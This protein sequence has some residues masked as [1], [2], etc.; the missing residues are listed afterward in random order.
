MYFE[1]KNVVLSQINSKDPTCRISTAPAAVRLAI[2][3]E[4][5]GLINPPILLPKKTQ[6][7]IIS[8]FRRI[9]ACRE[10]GWPVI[11]A[12][13]VD[14]D[15]PPLDCAK[16]AI[17]ENASQRSLNLIELTRAFHMLSVLIDDKRMMLQTASALGL[18]ENPSLVEKIQELYHLPQPIQDGILSDTISLT[19]ALELDKMDGQ[20]G[21]QFLTLFEHLKLGLNRQREFITLVKEIAKREKITIEQV[22]QDEYL[23]E[24]LINPDMDRVQKTGKIRSY[25]R[26][27]RFPEITTAERVFEKDVKALELGRGLR[28]IP[29]T[30]FESSDYALMIRFRSIDELS[31]RF[32]RLESLT[33]NPHFHKILLK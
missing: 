2:S 4:K 31:T 29:P 14:P 25:L 17:T 1:L 7:R 3:I 19:M 15:T 12:R 20:A 11:D 5:M 26:N 30:N 24:N 32:T 28:L 9:A 21:I 8:G 23:Q 33:T 18:P 16:L 6:Y 27:R 22:I 10:L 13:I